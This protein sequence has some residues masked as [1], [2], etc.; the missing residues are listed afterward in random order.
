M[1]LPALCRTAAAVA[2]AF[3]ASAAQ[4]ALITFDELEW[5]PIEYW[6]DHPVTDQYAD[7][8]VTFQ[9]GYLAQTYHPDPQ[10]PHA[11]QYLLGSIDFNV[12][13]SGTLPTYVSLNLSSPYGESSESYVTALGADNAVVGRGRTGGYYP[14]GSQ[15]PPMG[16]DL[17][18][19]A[20]RYITFYSASGI[21]SLSFGDAY[22][23]RLSSTIDNLYFGNVPAVPEPA[24]LAL[25]AAGLAVVT[26]ARKRRRSAA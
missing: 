17:P 12:T 23:S 9:G 1:P 15:D 21:A 22:G 13:F 20:N 26:A 7:L 4:A 19:Q 10:P 25:W 14:D 3:T 24:T 6:F 11:N 18:Y 8:G 16:Q 2:F 5:R